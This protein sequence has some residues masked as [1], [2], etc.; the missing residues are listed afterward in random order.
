MRFNRELRRGRRAFTLVDLMITLVILAI[1]A[2]VTL[3]LVGR[4]VDDT[5][6]AAAQTSYDQIRKALDLH[7]TKHGEW[8]DEITADLF[9]DNEEPRFPEGYSIDYDSDT[10]ELTLNTPAES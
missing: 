5:E 4:Y 2:A 9:K 8:P 10:G 3:P 1:L 7:M 6:E